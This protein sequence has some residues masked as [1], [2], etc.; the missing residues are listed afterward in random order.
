[1][2][3]PKRASIILSLL[4]YL[5]AFTITSVI[6]QTA[7][8]RNTVL[9]AVQKY[10]ASQPINLEPIVIIGGGKYTAPP[11]DNEAGSK[12]FISEYFRGG[13]R[14][15]MIFGGGDAGTLTVLKNVEPGCVGLL[16]EVSLQTTAKL[17]GQV[18]ALAT[19]SDELGAKESS[20][21]AP[22][23]EER[24]AA[25]ELARDTFAQKGV[26][27]ALIKTMT[28]GNLTAT[29]LERNGRFDL[30]GNFRI[31]GANYMT[32]N[33]F[34]VI[35][36]SGESYKATL[37]WYQKGAEADYADRSLVDA[38]DLDGD[39]MA[40]VIAE[41]HYYESNDYVIYKKQAG[42]WREIYQGGGG[43]C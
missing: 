22:T 40:E 4:V 20:R 8:K 30:I 5:P 21:R 13:R 19:S 12:K 10:D 16:A 38:V 29:D 34:M 43:G 18:Q 9:F 32:Y 33:L 15:R 23:P 42:H 17:G 27:A 39:G 41:G 7:P 37:S 26:G 3:P 36:P 24:T 11:V 14:Y 25:L 1:M 28:V 35:E 31:E 6:A 2:L